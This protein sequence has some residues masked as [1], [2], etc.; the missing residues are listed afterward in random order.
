ME[1]KKNK[2]MYL[3]GIHPLGLPQV[4]L[5]FRLL[6][7]ERFDIR[8]LLFK[9]LR[10]GTQF[11]QLRLTLFFFLHLLQQPVLLTEAFLRV[12]RNFDKL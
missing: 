1:K 7:H 10:V 3:D 8:L 9:A 4:A 6:P 2:K 12:N 5:Q 11:R